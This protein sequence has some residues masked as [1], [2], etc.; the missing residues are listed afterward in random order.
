M[1]DSPVPLATHHHPDLS[2]DQEHA[3]KTA[4][5][6]LHTAVGEHFGVTF[7]SPTVTVYHYHVNE[8]TSTGTRTAGAKQWFLTNGTFHSTPAACTDC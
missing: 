5:T 7:H 2:I 6:R 1:T 3:L 8:Q 4:A